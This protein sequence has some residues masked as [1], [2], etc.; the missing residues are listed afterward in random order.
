M[1]IMDKIKVKYF[2]M[3]VITMWTMT[4]CNDI[5]TYNENYDDD[6]KSTGTPF[7]NGVYDS[8][9]LEF[10]TPI[11]NAVF[12]QMVVITGDNLAQVRKI[13]FNDVEVNLSEVYATKERA[14]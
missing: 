11:V 9:D 3:S 1:I 13:M 2:L 14:Y 8:E 12:E 4:S 7:I 5:V 10:T 6:M